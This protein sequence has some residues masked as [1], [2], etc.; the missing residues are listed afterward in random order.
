MQ[1]F[2]VVVVAG[3]G[4]V[5]LE[6]LVSSFSQIGAKVTLLVPSWFLLNSWLFHATLHSVS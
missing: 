2:F 5:S 6:V 3:H 1:P 4:F